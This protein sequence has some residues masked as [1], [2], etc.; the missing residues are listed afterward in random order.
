MRGRVP[1]GCA[2]IVRA[3]SRFTRGANVLS[4]TVHGTAHRRSHSCRRVLVR[5]SSSPRTGALI[6]WRSTLSRSTGKAGAGGSS[7]SPARTFVLFQ[8]R[9][10]GTLTAHQWGAVLVRRNVSP[11]VRLCLP[12]SSVDV[13]GCSKFDGAGALTHVR[14]ALVRRFQHGILTGVP[15]GVHFYPWAYRLTGV[16][17]PARFIFHRRR[18]CDRSA[19]AGALII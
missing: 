6:Q 12:S 17:V 15:W 19:W 7:C 4:S 18:A 14:R 5:R 9:A 1:V 11:V 8:L 10:C 2:F 3:F 16:T 13:W